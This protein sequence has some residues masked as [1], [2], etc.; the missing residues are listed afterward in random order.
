M[1]VALGLELAALFAFAGGW[2]VASGRPTG[3]AQVPLIVLASLAMGVHSAAIRELRVPG[4]SSTYLT[5]TL[6]AVIGDLVQGG[7]SS[8]NLR[9]SLP[10]LLA[11]VAGAA[12][13]GALVT[14]APYAAPAVP[15]VVLVA[16]IVVTPAWFHH[17]EAR[18][19]GP[20]EPPGTP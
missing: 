9:R 16:V 15:V 5:G 12:A 3:G 4:L 7:R 19:A 20:T 1:T 18:S 14:D 2:A 8:A 10:I 6:T 17:G 11:V 13:G